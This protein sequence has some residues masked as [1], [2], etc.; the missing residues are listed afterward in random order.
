MDE[1]MDDYV[2]VEYISEIDNSQ[3]ISN[4]KQLN[5]PSTE[6]EILRVVKFFQLLN[7]NKN[8][9]SEK[10]ND[11]NTQNSQ[12]IQSSHSTQF[13]K[14]RQHIINQLSSSRDKLEN[15]MLF[16]SLATLEKPFY[17]LKVLN[18]DTEKRAE[19]LELKKINYLKK[20][21]CFTKAIKSFNKSLKD[22]SE[23]NRISQIVFRELMNLKEIGFYV[24]DS[25]KFPEIKE[26]QSAKVQ[27]KLTHRLIKLYENISPNLFP[28][29]TKENAFKKFHEKF[30]F[31]LEYNTQKNNFEM[32]SKFVEN[33][34]KK[35]DIGFSL[36]IKD[37]NSDGENIILSKSN[38]NRLLENL[39]NENLNLI[40]NNNKGNLNPLTN[41]NIS[42][43]QGQNK[44]INFSNFSNFNINNIFLQNSQQSDKYKLSSYLVFFSK[45]F[46]YT[47]FKLEIRHLL[48]VLENDHF[49]Y[50]NFSFKI[51]EE[52]KEFAIVLNHN[53]FLQV[54]IKMCKENLENF[55]FS[56]NQNSNNEEMFD[57]NNF[58]TD[59]SKKKKNFYIYNK[60]IK[61]LFKNII[62]DMRIYRI[63]NE[64]SLI[65]FTFNSA[66]SDLLDNSLFIS[67]LTKI[68]QVLI[69]KN[70]INS[71]SQKIEKAKNYFS[72][73]QSY[74]NPSYNTYIYKFLLLN[75]SILSSYTTA[76][77]EFNISFLKG[78]IIVE[79]KT[80][81]KNSIYICERENTQETLYKK[82][83]FNYLILLI[84]TMI[85]NQLN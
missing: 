60:L 34:S 79:F 84:D 26:T 68:S 17:K 2:G 47:L 18:I 52:V 25:F 30:S 5:Q 1:E 81:V 48:R 14:K 7:L 27:L 39:I 65:N 6:N 57:E 32:T 63:I 69:R 78:N 40:M 10:L 83:D 80:P 66:Y 49:E 64:L 82:V 54:K 11:P 59:F 45:Y 4:I 20:T 43:P 37:N 58:I 55:N 21:D 44:N 70:F 67:N 56:E 71:I 62:N 46:F 23:H 9:D 72:N 38:F 53:D 74:I 15:L 8:N 36:E 76:K 73:K 42:T 22:I 77:I 29:E 31:D 33:F 19:R 50:K 12:N 85:N 28:N 13:I 61:I 24:E 41:T 51:E 75:N 35:F 3:T 16:L